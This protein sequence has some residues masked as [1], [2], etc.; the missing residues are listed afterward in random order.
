M[1]TNQQV[2]EKKKR[3][4]QTNPH[5]NHKNMKPRMELIFAPIIVQK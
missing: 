5:E 4:N 2:E 1:N 3:K